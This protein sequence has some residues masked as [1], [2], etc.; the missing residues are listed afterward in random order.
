[1][2]RLVTSAF[3]LPLLLLISVAAPPP[4]ILLSENDANWAAAVNKGTKLFQQLQSGCY[5]DKTNPL[6]REALSAIGYRI[7]GRDDQGSA[8]PPIFGR[9]SSLPV[10]IVRMFKWT[11]NEKAYWNAIIRRDCKTSFYPFWSNCLKSSTSFFLTNLYSDNAISVF[12]TISTE[13][14]N[15]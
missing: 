10:S 11:E 4:P 6:D 5:P 15:I 7:T 1:M 8:W 3:L 12:A 9:D 2:A 14:L 13:V